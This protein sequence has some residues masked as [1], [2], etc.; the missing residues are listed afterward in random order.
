MGVQVFDVNGRARAILP[1]PG[2]EATG[3]AFGGR[4]FDTLYVSCVNRKPYR[5]KL[6]VRGVRPEEVPIELPLWGAG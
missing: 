6:K 2:G 1:L 5:R 4:N 3:L